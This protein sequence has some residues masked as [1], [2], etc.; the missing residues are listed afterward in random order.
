MNEKDAIVIKTLAE[1]GLHKEVPLTSQQQK[2]F[3]RAIDPEEEFLAQVEELFH[4]NENNEFENYPIDEQHQIKVIKAKFYELIIYLKQ[5]SIQNSTIEVMD[6]W[7]DTL[8]RITDMRGVISIPTWIRAYLT[9][10]ETE[11]LT[12]FEFTNFSQKLQRLSDAIHRYYQM[13]DHK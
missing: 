9:R 2:L 10:K 13:I 4:I 11:T 3:N 12:Q 5:L 1:L 8:N 6:G 7:D